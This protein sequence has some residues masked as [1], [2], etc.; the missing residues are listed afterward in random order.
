MK[1]RASAVA[2]LISFAAVTV[3]HLI[4]QFVAPGELFAHVTQ[5]LLMPLLAAA[6]WAGT[7][8]PRGRLVWAVIV[9]LFFSWL[10]DV[11][12]RFVAGD[13]G[14]LT[15]V[16][17]FLIAQ[18]WYIV[19]F[20]PSWRRSV[21]RQPLL[22]LPYLAAFAL[23]VVFCAGG[24][25]SLLVPVVIYGI[26]LVTMAVLSTGLGRVAGL[27][28]AI[29]F[30][31]D[32]M[33]ALRTFADIAPPA[34]GFWVMLTYSLGQALIVVAVMRCTQQQTKKES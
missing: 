33:I 17:C 13:A 25:G 15:M 20:A 22:L 1:L 4:A 12:P 34:S 14:F 5:S 6:L 24:A 30:V 31:S 10:G 23:L 3:L 21:V 28:G 9:A 19:A 18:V 27:G 29:F 16:G 2:L 8:R 26:A 7:V 32:A 11:L